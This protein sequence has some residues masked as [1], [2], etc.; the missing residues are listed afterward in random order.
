MRIWWSWSLDWVGHSIIIHVTWIY[1]SEP[2]R[3]ETSSLETEMK[4]VASV[5]IKPLFC[6]A[7]SPY[8]SSLIAAIYPSCLLFSHFKTFY[9]LS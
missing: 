7:H 9:F 6:L 3:D 5:S 4:L 2:Q 8:L 1:K